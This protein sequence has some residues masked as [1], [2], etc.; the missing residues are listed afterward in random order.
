MADMKRKLS[1][2]K[3]VKLPSEPPTPSAATAHVSFRSFS[4]EVDQ[5]P[6]KAEEEK[7]FLSHRTCSFQLWQPL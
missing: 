3:A 6:D 4:P 1:S 5:T 7:A 2:S